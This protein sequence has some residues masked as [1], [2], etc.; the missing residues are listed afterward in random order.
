[1]MP[2][3]RNA[4]CPCGSG[5]K[6]KRCCLTSGRFEGD[7]QGAPASAGKQLELAEAAFSL[8]DFPRARRALEPLL[9]QS[10]VPAKVWAMACRIEMGEK[11]FARAADCMEKALEQEPDNASYLY[12]HATSLAVTGRLEEAVASYRRALAKKPDMWPA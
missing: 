7:A 8:G 9:S 1:M 3:S 5:K 10:R 12:N 6:Y 2:V 4:P 11:E